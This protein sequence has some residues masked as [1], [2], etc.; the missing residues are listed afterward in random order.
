MM[1]KSAIPPGVVFYDRL[2]FDGTAYVETD[3]VPPENA[4]FRF[5]GGYETVQGAQRVFMNSCVGTSYTGATIVGV[6]SGKRLFNIY[7]QS[8]AMV[9]NGLSYAWATRQYTFM[10]T[11]NRAGFGTSPVTIT[12]GSNIPNGPVLIGTNV[13]K[14][15]QP[16]S[17]RMGRFIIYGPDAQD[18]I[19]VFDLLN[20]YTPLYDLR[21]CTYNGEAGFW[22]METSKFYGNTAGAGTLSVMNN[23]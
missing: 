21:P 14:N 19:D 11:P 23:S 9:V 1:A 4:S 17:G 15:G 8:S 22:C 20:N 12:K 2:V 18:A 16:F 3:I 10:L 5:T 7:Y 6:S 13:A